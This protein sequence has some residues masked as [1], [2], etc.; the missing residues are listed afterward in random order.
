[1]LCCNGTMPC[2]MQAMMDGL[3][4]QLSLRGTAQRQPGEGSIMSTLPAPMSAPESPIKGS[5]PDTAL[6][7][8]LREHMSDLIDSCSEVSKPLSAIFSSPSYR[9]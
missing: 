9:R 7:R 6:P 3:K 4:E 8:R 1:M 2:I 5:L